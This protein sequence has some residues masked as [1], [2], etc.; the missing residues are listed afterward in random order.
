MATLLAAPAGFPDEPPR[1]F[2][3]L[4]ADLA[5]ASTLRLETP[6]ETWLPWGDHRLELLHEAEPMHAGDLCGI[7]PATDPALADDTALEG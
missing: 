3:A 5:A 1:L 6:L 7:T 2:D 4:F